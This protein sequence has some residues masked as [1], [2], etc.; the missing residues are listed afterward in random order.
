MRLP[1]GAALSWLRW[2]WNS[3]QEVR[4]QPGA[5]SQTGN[6]SAVI[7]SPTSAAVVHTHR[8]ETD[9][10]KRFKKSARPSRDREVLLV[11]NL[12]KSGKQ[13]VFLLLCRPLCFTNSAEKLRSQ[14]SQEESGTSRLRMG[15]PSTPVGMFPKRPESHWGQK[16]TQTCHPAAISLPRRFSAA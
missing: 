4:D 7:H 14:S 16:L 5:E 12:G 1:G 9:I 11:L 2:R 15:L 10:N 8:G 6:I 13:E 3:N